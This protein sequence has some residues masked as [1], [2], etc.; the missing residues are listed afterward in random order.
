MA[1]DIELA[2]FIDEV[3]RP[4]QPINLARAALQMARY[5]YP[6]LNVRAYELQLDQ[7]ASEYRDQAADFVN[8]VALGAFLFRDGRF[9]GNECSYNDPRNSFLN[10]VLERRLGIPISLSV[11]FLEVA[12]RLGIDAQG[13]GLPGHFIVQTTDSAREHVYLD[14]F[15]GG[16]ILSEDDCRRRVNKVTGGTVSF[17]HSHLNPVSTKMILVRMLNN[18]KN[19]YSGQRDFTRARHVVERLL[20]L[21]PGDPEETRN[22]GLILSALG[23]GRKAID[24]LEFY[25]RHRPQAAD[26][27][28]VK[29][30]LSVLANQVA[31]WN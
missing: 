18:L 26:A 22:L 5:E 3:T 8:G 17:E 13:V 1:R 2:A 9:M 6:D 24:L 12:R 30:Y 16:V 14:P 23:Q 31:R 20:V 27:D 21:L 29:Q 15:H 28:A 11:V 4:K 7:L 10:A 25:L 19:I